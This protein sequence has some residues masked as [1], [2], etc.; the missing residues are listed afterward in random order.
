[1]W[2]LDTYFK[3]LLK[4]WPGEVSGHMIPAE[5]LCQE[6]PEPLGLRAEGAEKYSLWC[7]LYNDGKK[8]SYFY[9]LINAAI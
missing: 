1:M 9:Y 7:T 2:L 5:T 8:S 3:L 6:P 4:S